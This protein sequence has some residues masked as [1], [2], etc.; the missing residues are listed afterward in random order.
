[1]AFIMVA[2]IYSKLAHGVA[3][4]LLVSEL[5]TAINTTMTLPVIFFEN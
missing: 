2:T 4:T 5:K 1:M 3:A